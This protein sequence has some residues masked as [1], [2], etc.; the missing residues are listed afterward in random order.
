M[1]RNEE[2]ALL[3][4]YRR[5]RPGESATIDNA[6]GLINAL[7]FNPRRY[8]LERVGRF[9]LNRKLGLDV[10]LYKRILDSET[11]VKA[12]EY[13]VCLKD[14]LGRIDDIDH[15]GNRRIKTICELISNQVRI[16]LARVER[17]IQER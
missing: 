14:G 7:F 17:S 2:E 4:F 9:I 13:L 12:I 6:Q 15:L 5:L 8:D 10:S 11:V 16:G 3:D 1:V